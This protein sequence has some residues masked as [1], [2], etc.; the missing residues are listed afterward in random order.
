[1]VLALKHICV[2]TKA[3]K[4]SSRS[5]A[6]LASN[7]SSSAASGMTMWWSGYA[8]YADGSHRLAQ[9]QQITHQRQPVGVGADRIGIAADD[10]DL[11]DPV[12]VEASSDLLDV[13]AAF[14]QA[15]RRCEA[16]RDGRR[17]SARR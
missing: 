17:R 16:R 1:M 15:V 5:S 12:F 7:A 9:R 6:C 10:E 13:I 4:P 14:D 2:L 3:S 8:G 11:G